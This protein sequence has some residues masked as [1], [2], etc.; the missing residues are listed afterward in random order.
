M[1]TIDKPLAVMLMVADLPAPAAG[2]VRITTAARM[3]ANTTETETMQAV[4]R[5]W[6]SGRHR[7]RNCLQT[8][9]S[10]KSDKVS[11]RQTE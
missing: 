6:V 10:R 8:G 9:T 3:H 5:T 2:S 4:W 1:P 7:G 11:Q